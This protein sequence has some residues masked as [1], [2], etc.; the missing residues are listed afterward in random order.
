LSV[1]SL[2]VDPGFAN[3]GVMAVELHGL[4]VKAKGAWLIL[5]KKPPKKKR[6]IREADDNIRRL[7]EIE[8]AF[9]AILHEVMPDVVAFERVPR[10]RNPAANRQCALAWGAMHAICRELGVPVLIYDTDEIKTKV[11]G[12][13]Q[14][15]KAQMITALKK[16]FPKFKGWPEGPKV[17]HVCDAGGAALCVENDPAIEMLIRERART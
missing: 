15:S 17:E 4:K 16:I 2:G 5:T 7:C 13:K 9:R 12:K 10:L 11:T 6:K 1:L 3:I 14:A 8:V